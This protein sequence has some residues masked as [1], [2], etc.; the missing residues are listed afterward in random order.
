MS[1][2][3]V[4]ALNYIEKPFEISELRSI[5]RSLLKVHSRDEIIEAHD[6]VIKIQT[7]EVLINGLEVK[8]T[9]KEYKLLLNFMKN[10]NHVFKREKLLNDISSDN[11]NVTDRVIDNH[12]SSL[13]KKLK[14]SSFQIKT[15]YGEGYKLTLRLKE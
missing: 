1:G 5:V 11:L 13:R 8:F 4:G 2:Y 6:I 10:I 3:E 9:T 15:V 7:R 12:I 14:N